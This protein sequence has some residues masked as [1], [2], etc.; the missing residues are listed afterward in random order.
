MMIMLVYQRVCADNP[1]PIMASCGIDFFFRHHHGM[2][3]T[4]AFFHKIPAD[5]GHFGKIGFRG[6]SGHFTRQVIGASAQEA[7]PRLRHQR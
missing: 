2:L 6:A 7:L 3:K 5:P 4:L 1:M